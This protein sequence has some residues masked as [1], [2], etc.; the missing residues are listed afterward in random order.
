MDGRTA[1]SYKS[2]T[3]LRHAQSMENV[4]WSSNPRK[5]NWPSTD[6]VRSSNK[7]SFDSF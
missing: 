4:S 2:P 1:S 7:F 6:E 3:G 5:T